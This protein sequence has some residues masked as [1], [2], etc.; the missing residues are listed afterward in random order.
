MQAGGV[1]Y[2]APTFT[3]IQASCAN[4][5]CSYTTTE[6]ITLTQAAPAT[7][8]PACDPSQDSCAPNVQVNR[9]VAEG[10]LSAVITVNLLDQSGY[11]LAT[12]SQTVVLRTMAAPPYVAIAGSREGT[13]DDITA[14]AAAGDDGGAPPATPNP[15]ATAAIGSASDTTVRVQYRDRDAPATCTDGSLWADSSYSTRAASSGWSP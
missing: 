11:P 8:G 5:S 14:S 7:P 4:A 2:P 15:C 1:P 10:R 12:R 13:F 9:Y 6:T 3:P